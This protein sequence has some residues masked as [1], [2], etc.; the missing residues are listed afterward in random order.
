ML[1]AA[2]AMFKSFFLES[3]RNHARLWGCRFFSSRDGF[4]QVHRG[5]MDGMWLKPPKPVGIAWAAKKDSELALGCVPPPCRLQEVT[6]SG[7]LLPLGSWHALPL[8]LPLSWLPTGPLWLPRQQEACWPQ[9]HPARFEHCAHLNGHPRLILL[10]SLSA[11]SF[12]PICY[13]VTL[14]GNL[15]SCGLTF[16]SVSEY[17]RML[18]NTVVYLL[19]FKSFIQWTVGINSPQP[20]KIKSGKWHTCTL[21]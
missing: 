19:I 3:F 7:W 12:C 10:S 16:Q 4:G 15:P 5:Q 8:H 13:E 6:S 21:T 2:S 17:V 1:L 14:S 9:C 18:V 20:V 11:A